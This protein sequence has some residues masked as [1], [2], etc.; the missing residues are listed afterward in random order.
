MAATASQ[1]GTSSIS[2]A[3]EAEL[4]DITPIGKKL[5]RKNLKG[6]RFP[7][8]KKG[9][10]FQAHWYDSYDWIE[11]SSVCD[12]VYC[13]PCRIFS[14]SKSTCEEF[15]SFGFSNWNKALATKN[16]FQRH[17]STTGHISAMASWSARIHADRSGISINFQLS[18]KV[19][20]QRRYYTQVVI[21]VI[22]FLCKNE[23]ALRGNWYEIT[24]SETGLLNSLFDFT[25]TRDAKLRESEKAMPPNVTYK[26]PQIQNE[27][28]GLLADS[29][30]AQIVEEVNK[31]P[32]LTLMVDGTKD[33]N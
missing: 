26:S 15:V 27:I 8:N 11:Y 4:I 32:F 17:A 20:E 1:S 7:R 19:L 22:C 25:L 30:C 21:D 31:A 23:L 33:K 18:E 13:Y 5:K 12:A 10:Y 9:R 16:D 2:A 29:L 28:I 6:M 3:T 24:E 14:V